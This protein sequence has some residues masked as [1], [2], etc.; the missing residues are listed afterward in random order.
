MKEEERNPRLPLRA[1]SSRRTWY[2]W[3]KFARKKEGK[4]KKSEGKWK[5]GQM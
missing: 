1:R 5:T 2:I 4:S 3:P